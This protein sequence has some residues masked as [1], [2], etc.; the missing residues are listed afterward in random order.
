[1]KHTT[2]IP[3]LS[4]LSVFTTT[5]GCSADPALGDWTGTSLTYANGQAYAL[6]YVYTEVEG[7]TTYAFTVQFYLALEKE[8]ATLTYSYTAT[9]NGVVVP[10]ETYDQ[11]SALTPSKVS[12]G[13]WDLAGTL[14]EQPL[15]LSCT[16]ADD[17]MS[18]T[19]TLGDD[20]FG[21]DWARTV[22]D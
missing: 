18:C 10:D 15:A 19:G 6:P 8:S 22:L 3:A 14:D 16:A 7:D 12:R 13:V 1:M 11:T 9:E 5:A 2:L 17:T 21:L 20:T 4:A